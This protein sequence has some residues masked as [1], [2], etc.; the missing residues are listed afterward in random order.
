[1]E[2]LILSA[3]P[4]IRSRASTRTIMGDVLIALLPAVVAS[5]V[6]FGPRALLLEA[7]CVGSAVLFEWGFQTLCKRPVTVGD[8]SAAVTGLILALNLHVG[9]PLWQAVFGSLVAIVVVKQLFGGIGHNFANPAITA[10]IILL[11]AFTDSMT[12][13]E[14]PNYSDAVSSAT[15]LTILASGDTAGL[16]SLWEMFLGYTAAVSARPVPWL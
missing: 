7:V 10:R 8:L 12:T 11:L 6:F 5:V 14:L 16:P 1:M 9:I 15:P 4:H 3:A 2:R 13:W